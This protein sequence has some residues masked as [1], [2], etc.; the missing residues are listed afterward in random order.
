M[1]LVVGP[2]DEVEVEVGLLVGITGCSLEID[3]MSVS[4]N[5]FLLV[6]NEISNLLS[7]H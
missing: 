1:G 5:S 2:T 6:T 3:S 7:A 4:K